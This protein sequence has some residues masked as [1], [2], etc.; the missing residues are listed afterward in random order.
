[1]IAALL[2]LPP[3][4]RLPSF[5]PFCLQS[6]ST[7][8][9]Q[10]TPHH[11]HTHPVTPAINTCARRGSANRDGPRPLQLILACVPIAPTDALR[12]DLLLG[13][14]DIE[15]EAGW[16]VG[17]DPRAVQGSEDHDS[18]APSRTEV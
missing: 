9:A 4:F 14:Q 16:A 17:T 8:A 7:S 18:G 12:R 6:T 2:S 5:H 10:R 3:T 1:M 15:A 11:M 13:L